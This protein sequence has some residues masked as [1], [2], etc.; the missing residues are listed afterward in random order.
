MDKSDI[1]VELY[2]VLLGE[3][4]SDD[5]I[6][7]W[8]RRNCQSIALVNMK[9]SPNGDTPF[10]TEPDM[11]E[12][13]S[14]SINK[15]PITKRVYYKNKHTGGTSNNKRKTI[16]NKVKIKGKTKVKTKVKN[17]SKNQNNLW[18][19]YFFINYIVLCNSY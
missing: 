14:T 6:K 5:I 9:H 2:D 3:Y 15:K 1:G 10:L 12:I 19:K 7:S 18:N 8:F 17:K 4:A 16:K 11:K 13:V